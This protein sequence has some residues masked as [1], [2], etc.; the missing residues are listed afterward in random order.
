[1]IVIVSKVQL[2]RGL[3]SELPGG[4]ITLNPI[5]LSPG[6]SPGEL[7]MTID[8]GRLFVGF[9]PTTAS[10][11]YLRPVF[12]Y[13]NVEV[14]TENSPRVQELFSS[15]LIDQDENDFFVPISIPAQ[16]MA[17]IQY[18]AGSTNP[19]QM[20]GTVVSAVFEYHAFS[21]TGAPVKQGTLRIANGTIADTE[22][23]EAITGL[24]FG[25]R[26]GGTYFML[27]CANATGN[28]VNL[29]LRRVLVTG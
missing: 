29:Y 14:L 5:T 10:P 9:N 21:N 1:M 20:I 12:P 19:A 22:N 6:L 13:Q 11:N 26:D 24:T 18:P 16:S 27:Q 25:V 4:P 7:G 8:T 15:Y 17:D 2:R 3:E 28:N 23:V